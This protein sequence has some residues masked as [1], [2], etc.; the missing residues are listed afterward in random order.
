MSFAKYP[1]FTAPRRIYSFR[2][3]SATSSFHGAYNSSPLVP[4]NLNISSPP[5]SSVALAVATKTTGC[6]C[7]HWY[8]GRSFLSFFPRSRHPFRFFPSKLHRLQQI[9]LENTGDLAEAVSVSNKKSQQRFGN[10]YS[11]F[12]SNSLF[13]ATQCL[14]E[15]KGCWQLLSIL[16]G[17]V[18][19]YGTVLFRTVRYLTYGT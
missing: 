18:I 2:F 14:K 13:L 19:T 1:L 10:I 16:Y 15:F 8:C 9:P 12:V 3:V 17:A 7:H 6:T 5:E 4:N 11:H